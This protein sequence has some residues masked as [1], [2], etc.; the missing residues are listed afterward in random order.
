MSGVAPC[1]GAWIEILPRRNGK[2]EVVVAPCTGAWIEI[3]WAEW[4][5]DSVKSHPARVRGLK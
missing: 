3:G 5:V 1:T 2:T 4:S